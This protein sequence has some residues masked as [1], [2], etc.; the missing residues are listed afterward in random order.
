MS[1]DFYV[2]APIDAWPNAEQIRKCVATQGYPIAIERFPMLE[3]SRTVSDGALVQLDDGP[4]AYL[5]GELFTAILQPKDTSELNERM[6]LSDLKITEKDA[7]MSMRTRSI[8]EVRAASYVVS[9]IIVCFDGF[10]FDPQSNT[11]GKEDF[12][13]LLLIG[14]KQLEGMTD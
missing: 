10:G 4:Q 9:A 12:A 2:V 13:E 1:I 11:S 6:Q 3:A 5:E 8:A 14:T 7:V